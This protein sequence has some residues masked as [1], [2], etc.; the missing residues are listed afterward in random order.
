MTQ[1]HTNK[2]P[3]VS[4]TVPVYNTSAY[5]DR[6]ISSLVNQTL[7]ELEIILV[8]DGSTDNSGDI[9]DKWSQTDHRIKVLHQKNGGSSKARQTGLDNAT[10]EYVIVCDSDDWVDKNAYEKAYQTAKDNDADIVFFGYVAEFPDGHSQQLIR[11]FSDLNDIELTRNEIMSCSYYNSWNKLI[12]RSLFAKHNISYEPGINMGE[13][14]LIFQ[15]LMMVRP[16]K[17]S[18]LPEA[19]YH[20]R[21]N[22]GGYTTS[23]KPD[24]IEQLIKV[25][26]WDRSNLDTQYHAIALQNIAVKLAFESVRCESFNNHRFKEIIKDVPISY[27]YRS[28]RSIHKLI[29]LIAKIFGW[30]CGHWIYQKYY[31]HR[32][33]R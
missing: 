19:L 22:S 13:D 32:L 25:F 2:I 20:Y 30:R 11:E 26:E 6:C 31:L 10:G 4:I 9:C 7:K 14:H 33:D 29:V 18:S 24:Y 17:I 3:K 15:K 1:S 28:P 5:L 8:N 23:I 21:I 27:L 16:L 12:R